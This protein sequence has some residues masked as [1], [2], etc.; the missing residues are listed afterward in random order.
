MSKH[1]NVVIFDP[2]SFYGHSEFDLAITR[3]F[4]GFNKEFYRRYHELIP[5]Q[6]GFEKRAD[7]YELF[8]YLNHWYMKFK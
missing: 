6:P 2:A 1:T 4:G 8:H 3:M 7:L 5:R